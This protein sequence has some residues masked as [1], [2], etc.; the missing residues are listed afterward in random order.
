ME[1][2][3]GAARAVVLQD[4]AARAFRIAELALVRVFLDPAV[5]AGG[6][7]SPVKNIV[8]VDDSVRFSLAGAAVLARRAVTGCALEKR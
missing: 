6:D 2:V 7:A 5:R 8:V 3:G 4:L 1:L